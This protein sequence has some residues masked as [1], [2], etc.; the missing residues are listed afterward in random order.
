MIEDLFL[1]ALDVA[2]EERSHFLDRSCGDD[3]TLRGEVEAMLAA[4]DAGEGFRWM[5]RLGAEASVTDG[6]GGET[7]GDFGSDGDRIGPYELV[8]LIGRGGMGRV[9]LAQRADDQYRQ[10]VALK[11]VRDD[12]ASGLLA[13]RFRAERQILARL[14]HP[15]ISTLLDGG[16]TETGR[17][18][19]VMQ[20]EQGLPITEHCDEHR[21]SVRQRLELFATVCD[22]VHFAHANLVVHRDLK[23]SNIL[24]AADGV[25]KLLD[26][27]IAKILD[28]GLEMTR[29]VTQDMRLFSPDHAAPEQILGEP[30][31]TATDVYALGILLYELMVGE[32]PFRSA[33]T[34]LPEL[35]RQICHESPT[36]PSDGV[37][38]AIA[39]QDEVAETGV[40]PKRGTRPAAL[41]Q[42][43]KGDLDQIV[44][45][46]LRKEPERRYP[47]AGQLAEDI[48]RFLDGRPV[49]AQPDSTRYR[50]GKFVRRHRTGVAA[51]TALA[52]LMVVFAATMTV[53]SRRL[54]AER[55]RTALALD[56]AE[57][58]SEFLIGLFGAANPTE[59]PARLTAV[60]LLD[61]GLAR[62]EELAGQPEVQADMFSTVGRAYASLA[63]YD[64][65]EP[66]LERSLAM[67]RALY[68]DVHEDVAWTLNSLAEARMD[69]RGDFERVEPLLQEALEIRRQLQPDDDPDLAL[70]VASLGSLQ[71]RRQDLAGAEASFRES[72]AILNRA[73]VPDSG[74]VAATLSNLGLTLTRL[75]KTAEADTT[76]RSA[77][78]LHRAVEGEDHPYVAGTLNSLG[79]IALI[80]ED[81][82]EAESIFRDVLARRETLYGTEHPAVA[83]IHNNLA[84]V[85]GRQGRFADAIPH[86]ERAVEIQRATTGPRHPILGLGLKNLG[87]LYLRSGQF[88]PAEAAFLE[89]LEINRANFDDDHPQIRQVRERLVEVYTAMDRPAEATR[90]ADSG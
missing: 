76:L 41:I 20:Y 78:A 14:Q 43:L 74:L 19:L 65:A 79:E 7:Q 34:S 59:E 58:V 13:E 40:A 22:A 9:Y 55:D 5:A 77:L 48:R 72:L 32:R 46:A 11:I 51:A 73:E 45:K 69:A 85:F 37:A 83:T 16:V 29:P 36:R 39:H 38:A 23:P 12:F 17:P 28:G 68:G 61:R 21:L 53:Q 25:P 66:L 52:A 81:F 49:M 70:A 82:A 88:A 18:F 90:Y 8:R 89:S 4:E 62:A 3:P 80:A 42:A 15:N 26:F 44:L 30:I 60:D 64:K 47:S 75:G 56:R 1:R 54:A 6:A 35:H 63:Q 33:D 84:Q 24:V 86:A 50:L 71:Y 2:P 67:R 31:T 87:A 27:G 57:E 10:Q